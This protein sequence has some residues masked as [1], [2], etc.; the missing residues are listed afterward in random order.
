MSEHLTVIGA[1]L[2]G[3]E[4]AWQAARQG[5][6]VRLY[7]MRPQTM[8]PA[9]SGG[10]FAELVCSNSLRGAALSNAVGL[11]KEEL[12]RGGS[13]LLEAADATAVAAGGALAVDRKRFSAYVTAAL[14]RQPLI[15]I[16]RE[17][18]RQ[19]PDGMVVIAAGPLASPA[20]STEISRLTGAEQLFFHDAIAPI[21]A[22][23]SIDMDKAFLASRYGKGSGDDYL[24]CP[25]TKEQY[26]AFYEALRQAELY[27]LQEFEEEKL[28]TG[29]MPVEAMARLGVDTMRYGPLK[30][31]GLT[32]PGGGEAYAVVQ[33]RREDEAGSMYNL[34]GFQTRL[35]RGEQQRVFRMIPGLENAEFLRFGQMH[36]NTY[37]NSPHLL[38]ADLR[39]R[40]QPRIFLA[41]QI[42]GVEGYVESMAGGWLAGQ[43]AARAL[44]SRASLELPDVTACGALMRYIS[45]DMGVPLQP[46]NINFG[47]LPPL[48]RRIRNKQEK[49]L[50]LAERA[51]TA[52]QTVLAQL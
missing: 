38:G 43:N 14:Q 5:V 13:L 4:A 28:F 2:A 35:R 1:G 30:P 44:Q 8:T 41:G 31:V 33:L 50:A 46:M 42:T 23:D 12:R 7:E 26:L 37:L 45:T 39:L 11:L 15:E 10:D 51:L 17:E 20:L 19:I 22:A 24:N 36:R 52:W 40:T 25:F 34:V 21:V 3:C 18:V 9:H 47:L 16:I 32:L 29:C 27:P 6:P 48:Q 49:N